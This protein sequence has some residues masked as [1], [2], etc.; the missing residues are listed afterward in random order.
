MKIINKN[1]VFKDSDEQLFRKYL[2]PKMLVCE[3]IKHKQVLLLLLS[4]SNN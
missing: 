4:N 2:Q 3:H 1:V